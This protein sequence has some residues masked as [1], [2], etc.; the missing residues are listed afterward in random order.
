MKARLSEGS[1]SFQCWHHQRWT[2]AAA[3]GTMYVT[4]TATVARNNSPL[5]S[6]LLCQ[7]QIQNPAEV[8]LIDL[9][10]T[11]VL[12]FSGKLRKGMSGFLIFF[13]IQR[14][15]FPYG[16]DRERLTNTC[17]LYPQCRVVS[18]HFLD[19]V[20]ISQATLHLDEWNRNGNDS[21]TSGWCG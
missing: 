13:S 4:A 17:V 1:H 7:F 10:F 21:V 11:M 2:L 5:S 20:C 16:R 12:W 15:L 3:T 14:L 9:N 19:R 8:H 18:D 6:F